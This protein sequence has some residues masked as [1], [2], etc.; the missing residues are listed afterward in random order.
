[1]GHALALVKAMIVKSRA[2]L[3]VV[4]TENFHILYTINFEAS[5]PAGLLLTP[6]HR[7]LEL[8]AHLMRCN[9]WL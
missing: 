4:P 6:M 3:L 7:C 8:S 5:V 9:Q 1:M 2:F